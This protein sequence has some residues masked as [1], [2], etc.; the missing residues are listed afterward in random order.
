[1]AGRR[2][3]AIEWLDRAV[4]AGRVSRIAHGTRNDYWVSPAQAVDLYVAAERA[5]DALAV[6]QAAF[7]ARIGPDSW[8]ALL[9]FAATLGRGKEQRQWAVETAEELAGRPHASG[10]DLI[11]IYLA[12]GLVEQAWSAAD[13]FGAGSAWKALAD[14]SATSRPREA[15]SL[16]P[17]QIEARL[18]YPDTR[19]YPE[20]ARM[21]VDMRSLSEAAG[22]LRN[23][24][25]YVADVRSRYARRTSL[26]K[27]LQAQRL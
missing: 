21:L 22:D 25:D 13:R 23:F 2:R 3:E 27:A 24:E 15:A 4:E 17:P 11:S 12:E 16:Y 19:V 6:L 10:A 9:E 1:V 26:I 8:R 20:L 5:T 14:A 18:R 7:T